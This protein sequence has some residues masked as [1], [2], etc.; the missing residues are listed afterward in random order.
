[1]SFSINLANEY[2]E[3][4]SFTIDWFDLLAVLVT[5]KSL[6]HHSSEASVLQHSAFFMVQLSLSY[7]TTGK[8]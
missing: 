7:I 3:L 1:M 5:L 4:I 2:S 6:L 8:T